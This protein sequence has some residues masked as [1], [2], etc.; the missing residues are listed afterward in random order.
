MKALLAHRLA[1]T[2]SSAHRYCLA[3]VREATRFAIAHRDRGLPRLAEIRNFDYPAASGPCPARLYVP[4]GLE[5]TGPAIIFF[6]GGGFVISDIDTH[7]ALCVRI[8][9]SARA[10]V[11]SI[12]YGL[13]PENPFPQQVK[14]AKSAFTWACGQATDLGLDADRLAVAGDSAGAYLAATVAADA[15]RSRPGSVKVQ[16]LFYPLVQLDDR[17]WSAAPLK[18]SR[19]LGRMA[20]AYINAQL[21]GAP[22][23]SLLDTI[24]SATPRTLMVTG[25]HLDPVHPDAMRYAEALQAAGIAVDLREYPSQV[26]GFA[27]LTHLSATAVTA[28][29]QLGTDIGTALRYPS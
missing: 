11:L 1:A 7:D 3:R 21:A 25:T 24:T 26:H 12:G 8:A 19:V 22:P 17:A 14:D 10:R 6:H 23:P 20:V 16:A 4:M 18:D 2:V 5:A 9:H 27:N 15:N 29:T 13:A 28:V